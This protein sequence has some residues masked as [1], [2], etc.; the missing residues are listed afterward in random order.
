MA[1]CRFN[2]DFRDIP[3]IPEMLKD[4]LDGNLSAYH[5]LQ[6]SKDNALVQANKKSRNYPTGHR[7]VLTEVLTKQMRNIAISAKQMQNIELL[8]K[9]NTFTVTTG[10]QLNLFTGP[11]FFIYKILQTIKNRQIP[12]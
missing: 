6:F 9:E 11:V 12:E 8:R 3:S 10:H 1:D 2:I 7:E 5:G 4:Y